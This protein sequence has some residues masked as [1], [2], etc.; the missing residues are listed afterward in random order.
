MSD[1]AP[2][3]ILVGVGQIL[4]RE[5]D[6]RDAEEPLALM[7]QA[8][9]AAA[10]DAGCPALLQRASSVR[11]IRGA[12]SYEDPG[13]AVAQ[14]LGCPGAETAISA[15]GGNFGQ[16]VVSKSCLALQRGEH[17]V[18]VVTGA[19]C[20]RSRAMAKRAGERPS[21]R[22]APGTPDLVFGSELPLGHPAEEARGVLAPVQVY[23]IFE[24]ALRHARGESVDAHRERI[25]KLWA[26][27][28]E[29][30]A[31]NPTAWIRDRKTAHEIATPGPDNPA[32]SFPYPRLM[33]ANPRVDMA[34]SVILTTEAVAIRLEIPREKWVYPIAATDGRDHEFVSERQS[35]AESPAIR[36]CGERLFALA[37]VAPSEIDHCDLYSCFPVA[38]Q[39]SAAELGLDPTRRLTVTGGLTFGGGPLNNY[40]LHGIA[41]MAEVLRADAGALGLCTG[42]GGYLTKHALCLYSTEKPQSPFR[43]ADLQEELDRVPKREVCVDA[44]G[45]VDVEAYT[46]MYERGAPK[47]AHVACLLPDGRRTWGN[48]TDA[49]ALGALVSEEGCGR[50]GRL[51]GAGVLTL[52]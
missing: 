26:S 15:F 29:V 51:D 43:H 30:A 48:V 20:G 2:T 47:T 12:W 5:D 19:E 44:E 22:K 11:V 38:V 46:V 40:T 8:A 37:D 50:T 32:V 52:G 27:F 24:I 14:E 45:R 23:P 21:R 33:N 31:G 3:P 6:W 4:Q 49:D 36:R 35:L 10:D 41:R 39:V 9:R 42:N 7:I 13:R 1:A 28:S 34:A 18:I 16:T 25:S 17:E